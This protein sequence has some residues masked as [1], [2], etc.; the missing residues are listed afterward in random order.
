MAEREEL[1]QLVYH[2]ADR[3]FQW[4]LEAPELARGMMQVVQPE[5]AGHL[6]FSRMQEE[7]SILTTDAL[8]QRVSDKLLR[9]P[10]QEPAGTAPEEVLVW[11]LFEHQSTPSDEI[12]V[13]L[14]LAMANRWNQQ[15]L[16]WDSDRTP[17]G[18]RW[19]LPVVSV[20]FYTGD[21][22]WDMEMSLASRMRLPPAL[23][24]YVPQWRVLVLNLKDPDDPR[25]AAADHPFAALLRAWREEKA[26][27]EAFEAAVMAAL[28]EAERLRSV[29]PTA[30][31]KAVLFLYLLAHHRRPAEEAR[32]VT[33]RVKETAMQRQEGDV[34]EMAQSL[35]EVLMDEGREMGRAEARQDDIIEL[36]TEKFGKLPD[37]FV[38]RVRS[39]TDLGRLG[40]LL[41]RVLHIQTLAD[42][43]I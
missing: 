28:E 4:L 9:V 14:L 12:M 39:I 20:V 13:A 40:D 22:P 43:G 36:L 31:R 3:A 29:D 18:E 16:G 26:S 21:E 27:P 32:A 42:M 15:R 24:P 35:A 37:D 1:V 10:Y 7:P 34:V 8:R 11:L 5:L 25:L 19:L 2:F 6:D 41:K 33:T 30:F 23:A 38:Q 17:A